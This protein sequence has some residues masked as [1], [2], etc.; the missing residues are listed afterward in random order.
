MSLIT[1]EQVKTEVS[2][3][4]SGNIHRLHRDK[5]RDIKELCLK[6]N[7]SLF[8]DNQ[9][10]D[11]K[12]VCQE[13]NLGI[14]ARQEKLLPILIDDLVR[15]KI[16]TR[17]PNGIILRSK[18]KFIKYKDESINISDWIQADGKERFLLSYP[19]KGKIYHVIEKKSDGDYLFRGSPLKIPKDSF[20]FKV[21]DTI[22][23]YRDQDNFISYEDIAKKLDL[24]ES[25]DT[26]KQILNALS[27]GFFRYATINNKVITNNNIMGQELIEKIRGRGIKLNNPEI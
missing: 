4:K 7:Q 27:Q 23:N 12:D 24:D 5:W 26:K 16:A 8:F 20:Y 11:L 14:R 9:S 1:I 22:Y 21:F 13:K 10:I 6:I 2:K 15:K 3:I 18:E 17:A 19:E 25:K